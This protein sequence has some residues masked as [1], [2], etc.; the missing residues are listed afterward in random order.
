MFSGRT[1]WHDPIRDGLIDGARAADWIRAEAE[2]LTSFV[3]ERVAR[4]GEGGM[5]YAADGGRA[6]FGLA[7][8]L[9]RDDLIA[10][11][12]EFF[13]PHCTLRRSV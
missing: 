5:R 6:D 10:L 3:H 12:N 7:S 8:H 9:D 11:Y 2:R 1:E 13:A 4:A